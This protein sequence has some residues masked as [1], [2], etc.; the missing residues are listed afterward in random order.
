MKKKRIK[1]IANKMS[2]NSKELNYK[3]I[4]NPY[5]SFMTRD[6]SS[7]IGEVAGS[8]SS[9]AGGGSGSGN[10]ES[11][12]AEDAT[13]TSSGY[14]A[15]NSNAS[16]KEGGEFDNIWI[17][18][19]I[20][21]IGHKPKKQ[22]FYIDGMTG[23]AE[24]CNVYVSGDIQAL[25]GHIGGWV[26]NK[27]NITS[28]GIVLDSLNQRILV[29][30]S[31]PIII[32]GINK[33]IESSNY[34]SGAFGSGF[35]LDSNLFEVGNIACRGMFR[36]SVFQK[37]VINV[38]SGSFVVTPNGDT[39]DADM[40][41][42]DNATLTIKGTVTLAV[43]DILR[44]KEVN[45]VSVEDEWMRV[46]STS[47]APTYTVT[48]DLAG[49]YTP[50]NNPTWKKGAAVVDYGQAGDG[51]VYMT[52]S[53]SNS[54]YLSIYDHTGTPWSSINTRLRLGNLN[55]YLGYSTDLYGIAIGETDK[56]LKYDPTNGLRIK[57]DIT[58]TGG[59]GIANLSD[60]GTLATQDTVD[61]SSVDNKPSALFQNFYQ[62]TAPST[63]VATGDYWLDSDDNQLYRYNGTTWIS[64]QDD[65]IA[66]AILDAGTAQSTADGKI[67]TF[68]QS[69]IPTSISIGDIWFD[70]DDKNKMYRAEIVG[71]N[72]IKPGEWVSV[73]D[74]DIEQALTDAATAQGA[75][76]TAQTTAD[77]K[78]QTYYQSAMP[79]TEHINVPDNPTYNNLVGDMWYDTDTTQT[80]RYSKIANGGNFDYIFLEQTI[81]ATVFDTIDGKR[82]VFTSTPT[83]P[84]Y[85]GDLWL[86][87]LSAGTGDLKKCITERTTGSYTASE[88]VIATEYTNGADWG[89][90]LINIPGTLTSPSGAGLYLSATNLGYYDSSVWKTYMD[91]SGNFYLGGTSGKLQ[92]VAGTDTLT[93]TGAINATSGK[94]GT[95]TN[96]WSV[97]ATGL[98]AVSTNTD[99]VINY[100]KLDFGQDST[101][102]FILGYDYSATKPKFEIG[103]SATK[104]LK[105]DGTDFTLIGGTITGGIIQTSSGTGERV[106]IDSEN[107]TISFYNSSNEVVAQLGG[108][109]DIANA[110]RITL[111]GTTATGVRVSG[112]TNYDIG[113]RFD[114]SADITSNGFYV[115]LTGA[116]N[117]GIGLNIDH[118]GNGGQGVYINV[119]SGARGVQVTNSSTGTSF[120]GNNSGTGAVL[121]FTVSGTGK[122][123]L[124]ERGSG[125]GTEYLIDIISSNDAN[126]NVAHF[127]QNHAN[128][129]GALYV[130][131]SSASTAI[132]FESKVTNSGNPL[133]NIIMPSIG[134]AININKDKYGNGIYI[135]MDDA[136][137]ND[138]VGIELD[139]QN[140]SYTTRPFFFS[141]TGQGVINATGVSGLSQVIRVKTPSGVRYI[142]LYNS[143]S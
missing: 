24:F 82:T 29:G 64:V 142:P 2:T 14:T 44:L 63:G 81:P 95:S 60:A 62:S 3:T 52:A 123:F 126:T 119:S 50:N 41:A 118:D 101:N 117:S 57:G 32:D 133:F 135:D 91:S 33:E 54:P 67:K 140:S 106:K 80:W 9:G 4:E 6:G 112:S 68:I 75:A 71:A 110:L 78:I 26:I 51:G 7:T 40:T 127:S 16:V 116:N 132:T 69:S 15:S 108:G 5:N 61:W 10:T 20:K 93:I 109:T 83:V 31:N 28:T 70:S 23:Y 65:D 47:N 58:I 125:S 139:L 120:Y 86:T 35:H 87:S 97:G 124:V 128:G 8:V 143:Y 19:W 113:Y 34:T 36:T 72:E 18:S 115:G 17:K 121:D 136:S 12:S 43:N 25:T 13:P 138:M 114:C 48:R 77:S 134:N 100:G 56:F 105:Y 98:T 90:N 27:T 37:N 129:G 137:D 39:L 103:S 42:L 21:S 38:I 111:D 53:D 104:I 102:G 66:Q 141:F 79:L 49:S 46:T 22:G 30:S 122:G 11:A 85:V 55:G 74:S 1:K 76:N 96:Y 88:W 59:S 130:E 131:T 73:R 107:N 92:W 84:Y 99:V 89:S 94:F 45:G